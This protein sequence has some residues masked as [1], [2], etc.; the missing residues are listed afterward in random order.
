MARTESQHA[1][2]HILNA[3][4]SRQRLKQ[5]FWSQLDYLRG[6]QPPSRRGVMAIEIMEQRAK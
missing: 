2:L 6:Y 1:A 3:L 4:E 5:L